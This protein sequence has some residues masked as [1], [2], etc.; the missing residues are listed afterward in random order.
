M[1]NATKESDHGRKF[2]K[3]KPIKKKRKK[4][5]KEEEMELKPKGIEEAACM[6]TEECRE[7]SKW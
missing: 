1:T 3:K 4:T 2:Y 7:R 5:E 6:K